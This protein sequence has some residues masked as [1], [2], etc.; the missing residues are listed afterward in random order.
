MGPLSGESIDRLVQL[1]EENQ[2][3]YT[4]LDQIVTEVFA[5]IIRRGEA[6]KEPKE[7]QINLAADALMK[8]VLIKPNFKWP[9]TE[10][11]KGTGA[12][13]V[14]FAVETGVLKVLGY[15]VGKSGIRSSVARRKILSAA[16]VGSLP[17]VNN[18]SYMH[19]W[20]NAN[21]PKRLKKIADCIAASA[22]S[23]KRRADSADMAY[24]IEDWE[25]DLS[26]LKRQ[27]YDGKYDFAWPKVAV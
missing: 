15:S 18:R 26:F 11:K 12:C 10:A 24:A 21:T 27:Y 2:S 9:T 23:A 1:M 3:D 7:R 22:R 4:I 8:L 16:Y 14:E 5:R 6:G 19:E 17:P 25:S 13:P 20:G